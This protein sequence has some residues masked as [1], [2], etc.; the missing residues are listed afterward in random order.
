MLQ[1]VTLVLLG[2]TFLATL[3]ATSIILFVRL[4][5]AALTNPDRGWKILRG[6]D[7]TANAVLN[8]SEDET[9]S[10]RAG[11]AQ[12]EGKRWGCILCNWLHQIDPD[13]CK[14]SIGS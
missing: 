8:G 13:H 5:W 7:Q 9:V 3:P 12:A 2:L 11:R 10:S 1:R 4:V 14:K 6:V